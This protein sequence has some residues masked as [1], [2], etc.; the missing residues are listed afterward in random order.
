M[1]KIST[2]PL[3][4]FRD[5]LPQES[6]AR[7]WAL[8]T[9][10]K[11]YGA[12]GFQP[13]I[14]PSCERLAT[15]QG[16]GAGQ[17]NEHL[18]FKLQKRGR[19]LEKAFTQ[20]TPENLDT[21]SD[22]GLRFDL[23]LL[24]ARYYAHFQLPQPFKVFQCGP[25]WRAERPQKGRYR[26]FF[27]CDV[28]VLGSASIGAEVDC[29]QAIALAM[30]QMGIGKV[31]FHLNDRRLLDALGTNLGIPPDQ[32]T[33]VLV[34]MDKLDKIGI[35]GVTQ[36]LGKKIPKPEKIISAF[37]GRKTL[38][39]WSEIAPTA[40]DSL[41]EIFACLEPTLTEKDQSLHFS[42]TLVRGQ[43]YYTGTIFEIR[44]PSLGYSLGGGG[45]Y[46][47]L[48]ELFDVPSTPAFGGSIGFERIIPLLLESKDKPFVLP[49][50][51]VFFPLFSSGLYG[52]VN[53]LAEKLRKKDISVDVFPDAVKLKRQ[54]RYAE[55]RDIPY[56][57]SIGESELDQGTVTCKNMKTGKEETMDESAF[58]IEMEKKCRNNR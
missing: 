44:K 35:D 18:I 28:D 45:R 4:G 31:E 12:Y 29:L 32:W 43:N 41:G 40:V 15:L 50:P 8:D 19:S 10:A 36:E 20:A 42:P 47:R 23:T 49:T 16:K 27:Q 6:A 57:A 22:M 1:D 3:S 52:K 39:E 37:T 7:A 38:R 46:D 56:V 34:T 13:I 30:H 9:I 53:D 51:Q 33:G 14:T 55:A 11:A 17:E 24:L 2:S 25:V 5:F 21:L 26:E 58:I 48:L 54:F